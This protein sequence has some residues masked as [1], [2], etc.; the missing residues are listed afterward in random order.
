[1]APPRP[2]RRQVSTPR[3]RR[4]V[5]LLVLGFALIAAA[6]IGIVSATRGD[7]GPLFATKDSLAVIDPG[8]NRVVADVPIGGTPRGVAVGAHD[9][10]TA[11]AGE[12]TVTKVDPKSLKARTIGLGVAA[13]DLVET[14]GEVWVATGVDNSVIRIDARSGGVLEN[15]PLSRDL[16]SSAYAIAAG[17]GAVWVAS[18]NE[19]SSIDPSTHK[20]VRR[21]RGGSGINDLAINAGSVWLAT[22]S[23][24]VFR[25]STTQLR[26]NAGAE[27]GQIPASLVIGNGSV[28]VAAPAPHGPKAAVWQLDERT[29]RVTDTIPFGS[30]SGFPPTLQLA[31]GEGSIWVASYDDGRLVRIDP[32]DGQITAIIKV[33]GH[34]SGVAVG[35]GRVWVTVS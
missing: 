29:A 16:E 9:I 2:P 30:P 35:A 21:W 32:E 17:G 7:N 33:G 28:W 20:I 4:P 11:N 12:G 8:N 10:W 18:G 23:E 22:S 6:V 1:L 3:S 15:I 34:P 31:Y 14:A 13:T 19:L 24:Q 5:A 27:L 26:P 25:L